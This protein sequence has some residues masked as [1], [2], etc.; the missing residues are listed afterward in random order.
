[1][2]K[3]KTRILFIIILIFFISNITFANYREIIFGDVI[4][5]M[6][7]PIF[8]LNNNELVEGQ[9]N[10]KEKSYYE[11]VFNILN[12]IEDIDAI[13]ETEFEYT[14]KII[15]STLNF[16]VKY[17]LINLE[18]NSQVYLNSELESEKIL[19]GTDKENHNYKLIVEWD[20]ENDNRN[21]EENLE[22]EILIKG[23]QKE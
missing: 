14:I 23:V 1:M 7:Y 18:N 16:P 6:K 20:L 13:S 22:V 15:P 10:S 9:I 17:T 4:V 21:L 11:N 5:K 2:K 3:R 19:L 8:L 12:Y